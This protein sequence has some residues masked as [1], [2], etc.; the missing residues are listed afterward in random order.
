MGKLTFEEFDKFGRKP[1]AKR[2]TTVIT[3]FSQFHDEAYVLSLNAKYGAGK[4]TFLKMWQSYL[5]E[6]DYKVIYINAWETDFDDEPLIPI[7]STLL[8][9]IDEGYYSENIK[10]ALQ[11]TLGAAIFAANNFINHHTGLDIKNALKEGKDK[12]TQEIGEDLYKEYSYKKLAYETL[13]KELKNYLGEIK[14]PLI[15]F[16]DELDRV[17]PDY[18][19]RFLEAIKHIFSLQG[20][21]FVLAVNREQLKASVK[22]LYG[23]IDFENYYLRFVTR[24]TDLP[25][26]TKIELDPF[27][28]LQL[29]KLDDEK[30]K[31][32]IAQSNNL[33]ELKDFIKTISRAFSL[34]PRQIETLCR[35]FAQVTS[36]P[37]QEKT[38]AQVPLQA[39]II[40]CALLIADRETYKKIGEGTMPVDE[41]H[42][43]FKSLDYSH[44]PYNENERY[45]ILT[46]LA[47]Y[48]R[49]DK[50]LLNNI[51]NIGKQ[52]LPGERNAKE[53]VQYLA[54]I[55]EFIHT[56]DQSRF[57]SLYSKI[58]EWKE[59][60]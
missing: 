40:L 18:S 32:E 16:V 44:P 28:D 57:Q 46:V 24:E 33:E 39:T 5:E 49:N 14:Q 7:I 12:Y 60:F 34:T 50:D 11:K 47:C 4:T 52:Y 37:N 17:R 9:A 29:S 3:K 43:Y 1:F 31:Y 41:L 2:L 35:T 19:V 13:H 56:P 8:D 21:C 53:F 27:I 38:A 51:G 22:Q 23:D 48:M 45:V 15:I 30:G 20:I 58:E 25:E 10:T 59:F 54:S 6:K 26:I 42:E 36:V 55:N